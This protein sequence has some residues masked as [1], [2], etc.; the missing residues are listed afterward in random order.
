M[1]LLLSQVTQAADRLP[2]IP[3]EKYSAEQK[4]AV[5][6]Y[7]A[8][9]KAP[10]FGPFEVMLHSPAMMSNAREVGDY[11]KAGSAIPRNL[12]ELAIL[13]IARDWNQDYVWYQHLPLALKAG[14]TQAHVDALGIGQKPANMSDDEDAVY[15]F[16][17][18]LVRNRQVS[19][20]SYDRINRRFG[21]KGV[22]DLT[23]L[24]AFYVHLSM[25]LNVAQFKLPPGAA[26]VPRRAEAAKP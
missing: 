22:V 8:V 16:V 21:S 12:A 9:R 23:S 25:Q 4:Q 11:M 19:D 26:G 18:E 13:Y 1:H 14:L 7:E 6:Q 2:V 20:Q 5:A 17:T 10:I 24:T 3:V 15:A